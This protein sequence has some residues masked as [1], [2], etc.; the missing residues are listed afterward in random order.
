ML[1][2][3]LII[4]SVIMFLPNLFNKDI[5]LQLAYDKKEKFQPFLSY[6]NSINKLNKHI[7]SIASS[8]SVPTQSL[9]YVILVEEVIE[10]RFYHGF[11]HQ[12]LSQNWIAAV[13]ERVF[14][15]GLSCKVNPEE[16]LQHPNAACSQQSIVM[17]AIFRKNN[18]TYRSVGFPHHF[19]MEAMI[20]NN[21]YYLDANMEPAITEN[22]RLEENWKCCADNLKKYYDP[23]RFPNLNYQFGNG[24]NA[25]FSAINAQPAQHALLFQTVTGYASKIIWSIPLLIL[26][27]RKRFAMPRLSLRF[28]RIRSKIDNP[29]LSS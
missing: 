9:A 29:V 8:R 3:I 27:Y 18:I 13:A 23:T 19:A 22:E 2:S 11:S 4:A 14:D 10:M 20:N 26:L 12:S 6:I 24:Q 16:I 17:M 15:Y 25:T 5:N 1:R 28:P 21:W 7:D